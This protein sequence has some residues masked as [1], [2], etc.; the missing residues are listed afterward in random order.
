MNMFPENQTSFDRFSDGSVIIRV[1][2]KNPDTNSSHEFKS[3]IANSSAN[4]RILSP[5]EKMRL[6][7]DFSSVVNSSKA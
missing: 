7:E 3:N 4:M 1:K 6:G 2:Q 5:N